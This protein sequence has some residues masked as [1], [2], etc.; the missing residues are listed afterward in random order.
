MKILLAE[1]DPVSLKILQITLQHYGHE[2]VTA[3]DGAQAWE[4]FD[5]EPFRVVVSDWMMPNVSGL[6]FCERVRRRPRTDYTYF[7]L[8][9]AINAGRDNLRKAMEAGIDDFLSK[10]LD[11]E[12]IMMRLRVAE[13]I[14]EY[15][16]QIRQLKELIPICMYCKRVRDDHDFWSQVESYIHAQTGSNFS[17]GICPECYGSQMNRLPSRAGVT[18]LG[19]SSDS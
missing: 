18:V 8:L 13:R 9:T 3:T 15:T 6:E 5:S 11:R 16:V 2:I 17:H 10:P 7:I 4:I 12:A 1:D 19:S 14:L